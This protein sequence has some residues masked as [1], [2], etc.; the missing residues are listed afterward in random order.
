VDIDALFE[1]YCDRLGRRQKELAVLQLTGNIEGYLVKEFVIAVSE[2]SNGKLFAATISHTKD[3]G[4][5]PGRRHVDIC[6]LDGTL[7]ASKQDIWI[8]LM[9]EAKYFSNSRLLGLGK[10]A[11]ERY[12]KDAFRHLDDLSEQAL[13]LRGYADETLDE[14]RVN[15]DAVPKRCALVLAGYQHAKP[16][17]RPDTRSEEESFDTRSEKEVSDKLQKALNEEFIVD[18]VNGLRLVYRMPTTALGMQYTVVLK[19]GLFEPRR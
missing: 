7:R 18:E 12:D 3:D 15:S 2:Y 11:G 5:T 1:K 6:V 9:L 13:K 16:D 4:G 14:I 17:V 8:V 10:S 19:A